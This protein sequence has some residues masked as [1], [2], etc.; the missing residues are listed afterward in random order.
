[1]QFILNRKE[2]GWCN[3][4]RLPEKGISSCIGFGGIAQN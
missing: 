1:M 4:C 2:G 3:Y